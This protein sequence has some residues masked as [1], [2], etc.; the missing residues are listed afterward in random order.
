MNLPVV[1]QVQN[2]LALNRILAFFHA[3]HWL[4]TINELASREHEKRQHGLINNHVQTLENTLTN[5]QF[6]HLDTFNSLEDY[7]S[8]T[9]LLCWQDTTL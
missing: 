5:A 2:L 6:P 4:V 7:T 8:G 9:L 1:A 3:E